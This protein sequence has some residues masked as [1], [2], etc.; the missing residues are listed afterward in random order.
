MPLVTESL[1]LSDY[2][3]HVEQL[4]EADS[5]AIVSNSCTEHAEVVIETLIS[6]SKTSLL[7]FCERLKKELY[8]KSSVVAKLIEASKRGVAVRILTQHQPET[9]LAEVIFP[10]LGDT[11]KFEIRVCPKE[12]EG[13]SADMNF[14]VM[15][16]KAFRYEN[17]REKH[18]AFA[19]ANS[20]ELAGKMTTLFL[21]LWSNA[22]PAPRQVSPAAIA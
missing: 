21:K 9:D 3:E 13:A 22:L 6:H 7:F 5:S 14:I 15:D 1:E 12:S 19:C 16:S 8:Q 11:T 4:F 2:R 10:H 20:Q 18:Q 17:D